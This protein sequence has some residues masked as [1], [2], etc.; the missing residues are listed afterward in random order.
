[1]VRWLVVVPDKRRPAS[2]RAAL[3]ASARPALPA[4]GIESTPNTTNVTPQD[5]G[6]PD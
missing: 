2:L 3:V 4:A 1:M 5:G 6:A